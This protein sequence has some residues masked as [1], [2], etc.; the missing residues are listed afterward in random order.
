G[1][2][3]EH[4]HPAAESI[5]ADLEAAAIPRERVLPRWPGLDAD[6]RGRRE[7]ATLRVGGLFRVMALLVVEDQLE[8]PGELGD[9]G[10]DQ[11]GWRIPIADALE[12]AIRGPAGVG[13]VALI[14]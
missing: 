4:E 2:V 8:M 13:A 5:G 12:V 9:V 7:D 14:R 1:E 3:M 11:P 6:G 10:L